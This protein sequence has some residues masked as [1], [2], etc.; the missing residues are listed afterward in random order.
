MHT[1]Y[2]AEIMSRSKKIPNFERYRI[3]VKGEITRIDTG[4]RIKGEQHNGYL[5][6]TLR[7]DGLRV[8]KLIH[9]L[10]AETFLNHDSK[11]GL[12]INHKNGKRD[13]NRLINL[14]VCTPSENMK[15]SY[16]KLNRKTRGNWKVS[17]E[18]IA[19]MKTLKGVTQKNIGLMFGIS[20]SQV[21][22]ILKS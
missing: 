21:G 7:F 1:F 19:L 15:H 11:S 4:T 9:V 18:E 8:R 22:R 17:P 20:Q 13:D 10:M 14:E 6:A 2:G 3:N 5:R 16:D 12:Q